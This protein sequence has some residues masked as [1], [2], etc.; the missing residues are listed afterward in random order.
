MELL[1]LGRGDGRDLIPDKFHPGMDVAPVMATDGTGRSLIAYLNAD[2]MY[3][4]VTLKGMIVRQD[5]NRSGLTATPTCTTGD[6]L[7]FGGA[8]LVEGGGVGTDPGTCDPW[9][10]AYY[11]PSTP[12][13]SIVM[14]RNYLADIFNPADLV[15]RE[16]L[17][18]D[19]DGALPTTFPATYRLAADS[20]TDFRYAVMLTSG[21]VTCQATGG[22]ITL[23]AYGPVGGRI[24]GTYSGVTWSGPPCPAATSGSFSITREPD[25]Q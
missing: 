5:G 23:T 18:I 24:A 11:T 2:P 25:S 19:L 12:A 8:H 10:F 14:N 1:D 7:D 22:T 6:F 16:Y 17:A 15:H 21:Q 9:V 4:G 13:T 20:T 3:G